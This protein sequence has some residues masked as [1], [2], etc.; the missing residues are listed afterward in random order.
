MNEMLVTREKEQWSSPSQC[1][2]IISSLGV[3]K[4]NLWQW[5]RLMMVSIYEPAREG[6][7]PRGW[8]EQIRGGEKASGKLVLRRVSCEIHLQREKAGKVRSGFLRATGLLKSYTHP[9]LKI[10][11]FRKQLSFFLNP[12]P[13]PGAWVQFI[14]HLDANSWFLDVVIAKDTFGNWT[15]IFCFITSVKM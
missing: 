15:L 4:I 2:I 11:T 12:S 9:W 3:N 8:M 5:A 14:K 13:S 1:L 6:F 10:F 7:F